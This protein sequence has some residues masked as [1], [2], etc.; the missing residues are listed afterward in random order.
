[1]YDSLRVG[2]DLLFNCF[3]CK[4]VMSLDSDTIVKKEWIPILNELYEKINKE[5]KYFI[6][7]GFNSTRH[8]EHF[9]KQTYSNYY[10][11]NGIGGINMLFSKDTYLDIIK[12]TLYNVCWDNIVIDKLRKYN[13]AIACSKPSVIEHIGYNGMWSKGNE[14]CDRSIDY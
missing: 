7:S 2:W 9:I 6:V 4:S 12:D 5:H 10:I 13:G 3:H 14:Q 1:M 11:K 8:S